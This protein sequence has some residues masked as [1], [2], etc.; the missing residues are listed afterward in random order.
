MFE[1]TRLAQAFD[2]LG[3]PAETGDQGQVDFLN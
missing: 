1:K 2:S 3:K